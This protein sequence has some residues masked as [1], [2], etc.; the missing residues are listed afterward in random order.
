M[1]GTIG[2]IIGQRWHPSFGVSSFDPSCFLL[3]LSVFRFV[4]DDRLAVVRGSSRESCAK[5]CDNNERV[6]AL[7][8]R[9]TERKTNQKGAIIVP[10]K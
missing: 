3:S 4:V 2:L 7:S 9:G 1:Y 8:L 5:K 10:R 6:V